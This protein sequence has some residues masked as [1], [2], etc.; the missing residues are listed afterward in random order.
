M[1]FEFDLTLYRVDRDVYSILDWIGDV[2]GLNEGLYLMFKVMLI[3]LQYNDFQHYLIERLYKRP[4]EQDRDEKNDAGDLQPLTTQKTSWVRQKL[5][6]CLPNCILNVCK[7]PCSPCLLQK[8]ERLFAKARHIFHAEV[9]I[10]NFLKRIRRLEAFHLKMNYLHGAMH[11]HD[12]KI[13]QLRES[14]ANEVVI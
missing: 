1:T 2:G 14:E 12:F 10:V 9:D 3:F 5:N 8:E 4:F 13:V 7:R 6:A 11:E